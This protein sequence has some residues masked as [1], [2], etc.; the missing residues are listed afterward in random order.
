MRLAVNRKIADVPAAATMP[1]RPAGLK[2]QHL[3]V[4]A[5]LAATAMRIAQ[6]QNSACLNPRSARSFMKRRRFLARRSS[7]A[8]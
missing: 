7:I 4:I 3:N 1:R 5:R 2:L 6:R 8:A